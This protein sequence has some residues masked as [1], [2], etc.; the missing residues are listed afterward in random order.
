MR[1]L[2][3][4]YRFY[5][6]YSFRFIRWFATRFS[7]RNYQIIVSIIIGAV[8]G[9]VAVGLKLLVFL[10][11]E[12]IQGPDPTRERLVF[13]FLPLGGV[14]CTIAFIRFVLRKP[15][16]PGLSELIYAISQKKVNLPKY[17]TYAHAVSSSLTV[18]FGGSVGLEAP[19]IRTGSAI[20]ANLARF[21]QVGRKRQTLFLACG[22][23]AGMSAIFNS[24]VAG[25]IF[26]FEVLLSEM[27]LHSF[28][29]LLISAATGAVVAKLLYYEQLFFLP[30][31]DWAIDGIPFYLLMGALCG[32]LSVIMIRTNIR[33]TTYFDNL[34]RPIV[35]IGLGG[36]AIGLLIFLMPPL[37][38]EGYE[39]V[40]N[41]LAGRF[42]AIV[43]HS[44]F[45]WLYDE[46]LFLIGFAL[47]ALIAKIFATS[48]T[49]AIGGNGGV[50]APSM[51]LGATLG[52]AFAHSINLLEWIELREANFIA[53]AMA[54][55]LSGV[56]KSPL[57][58]IFFIAELTGG[59]GL[60]V[61]LMLVS[62][63]SYFVCLYFEPHSIFTRE[64]FQK[65]LW[66]PPYE[67]DLSIL[68][69]MDLRGLVETNFRKINP[70]MSLGEFVKTIA[71]SRRNVFPVVD[72]EGHFKGIVLLDDVREIMF[73]T[74][75]YDKVFVKDVMHTPPAVIDIHDPM[76]K[77]MQ[78][79][80]FHNAWNLPVA[81]QGKY[82]GFVSKSSVFNRY[83]ELLIVRSGEL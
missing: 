55:L 68:K 11:K 25:V 40:N 56:F 14:L 22:A 2:K 30:T 67:R 9:L 79:F 32:L 58:A 64:L 69:E 80:D 37:F 17:E 20:G 51:F 71:K 15:V 12:W 48:I 63:L 33:I 72:E 75:K 43:E 65:G 66:V 61:P 21:L 35:K 29:P 46:P 52:F 53:V 4:Y 47:A 5:R 49:I 3:T 42:A 26:A 81:D 38:G 18:G 50:F 23:A 39:T 19:I 7:N 41:L 70:E 54:G 74:E 73:D 82:L 1:R 24:P 36:L 44:P 16:N 31:K 83:R 78:Q 34:K 60:F 6:Q 8:S 59:Y 13:V 77:V 76:E 45:Y 27:A 62:A 57:T 28:I 10:L